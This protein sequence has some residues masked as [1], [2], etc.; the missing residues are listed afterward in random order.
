MSLVAYGASDES[1]NSD[2]E[3]RE[4]PNDLEKKSNKTADNA[5][6]AQISDDD[7]YAPAD[8][9][10]LA[11]GGSFSSRVAALS[12]PSTLSDLPAPKPAE[13]SL[14]SEQGEDELEDEVKPKPSQVADAPK[15]PASRKAKQTARIVLPAL[16]QD[17][18][19]EEDSSKKSKPASANKGK[20]GGLFSL[21]PPPMHGTKKQTNRPLIPYTLTKR[22]APSTAKPA[23]INKPSST[24]VTS[25]QD[26]D[27]LPSQKH[28]SAFNA[29]TGYESD[30]DEDENVSTGG[31]NFFALGSEAEA[32]SS[33]SRLAVVKNTAPSIGDGDDQVTAGDSSGD[34]GAKSGPGNTGAVQSGLRPEASP[35]I[36]SSTPAAETSTETSLPASTTGDDS[37][38]NVTEGSGDGDD[39]KMEGVPQVNQDAPLDFRG[40]QPRKGWSAAP[41]MAPMMPEMYAVHSS[42]NL[43]AGASHWQ[44]QQHFAQDT[45]SGCQEETSAS[46]SGSGDIQQYMADEQFLRL[47]PGSGK[48]KRSQEGIEIIDANV[49]DYVDPSELMKGMT[50]ESSYQPHRKKDNM[51]SSQQRRKKQITYLAFQAKERELELKNQWSQNRMTKSH[52]RSKYG[53]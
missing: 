42:R 28:K 16:Q 29:L 51:P 40:S 3:E 53:F 48:R 32:V 25:S 44:A 23:G 27:S 17:S 5:D 15:P 50:E 9:D 4:V 26:T 7:D 34:S 14:G 52:A 49:D 30:S 13:P 18:D 6:V 45:F 20:S 36:S 24:S 1:D 31:L 2:A 37:G 10:Q 35:S 12:A 11:S 38:E 46:A 43:A 33:S 41:L 21:L 8:R 19:E 47:A 39:V 22:P